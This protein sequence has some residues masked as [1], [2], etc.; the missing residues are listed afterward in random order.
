MR[1]SRQKT[2]SVV[3]SFCL[4]IGAAIHATCNI[5]DS[6]LFRN[7]R[8]TFLEGPLSALTYVGQ[9]P[10]KTVKVLPGVFVTSKRLVLRGAGESGKKEGFCSISIGKKVFIRQQM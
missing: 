8:R 5:R 4:L 6:G 7:L 3:E 1:L 10:V 9:K 2:C